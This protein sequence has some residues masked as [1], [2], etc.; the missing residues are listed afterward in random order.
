MPVD[1][2]AAS[3]AYTNAAL[4]DINAGPAKDAEGMANEASSFSAILD[5]VVDDAVGAGKIS[6]AQTIASVVGE[7][8]IV[9]VVTAITAAEVTLE[10]VVA[11]RDKVIEAYENI[12]RMPI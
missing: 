9:D 4:K 7:S 11:V 5:G 8:E 12:M 10:T 6:E 1:S 3:R 2:L